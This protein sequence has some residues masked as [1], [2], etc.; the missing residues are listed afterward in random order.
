[1]SSGQGPAGP[2]VKA[3][4]PDTASILAAPIRGERGGRR[5]RIG[6]PRRLP[7]WSPR[8][9]RPGGGFLTA[10]GAFLAIVGVAAGRPDAPPG[11]PDSRAPDGAGVP[12]LD[13]LVSMKPEELARV[14]IAAMN[15]ACAAGLPGSEGMDI[16]GCLAT[17]DRFARAIRLETDRYLPMYLR[18]PEKFRSI[19]GYYRMQMLLTVL[20]QDLRVDYSARRTNDE[21]ARSFF[22]DSRDLLLNGLLAPPHTGTCASLPVL[23]VALGRRLGYPLHLVAT[24]GHLFARWESVDGRERFNVECTNG[25]MSS[26][27]DEH[28]AR[29]I[30]SWRPEMFDREGFLRNLGPREELAGFLDLRGMC[31]RAN[32]RFAE[33]GEVYRACA[34]LRPGSRVIAEKLGDAERRTWCQD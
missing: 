17:L 7:A 25:G 11:I 26:Y 22:A 20:K 33:A 14:D 34:R 13:A 5:G 28:Y 27:P 6:A 32:G 10:G 8:A 15:L 2:C 3:D 16:R 29:G 23:V 30:Y 18:A 24:R 4:L 12:A 31:L 21:P 9:A 19:E 1:M